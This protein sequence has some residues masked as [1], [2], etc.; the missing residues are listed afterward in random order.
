MRRGHLLVS[1]ASVRHAAVHGCPVAARGITV[2]LQVK[3]GEANDRED[4]GECLEHT[5]KQ[6]GA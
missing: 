5:A 4:I 6:I 1:N 2:N 3:P